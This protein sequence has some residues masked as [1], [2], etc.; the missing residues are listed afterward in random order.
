MDEKFFSFKNELINLFGY[1]KCNRILDEFLEDPLVFYDMINVFENYK[2]SI[3]SIRD[4]KYDIS[5][6][7]RKVKLEEHRMEEIKKEIEMLRKRNKEIRYRN[8]FLE[9]ENYRFCE[10]ISEAKSILNTLGYD[11][12]YN[13][14]DDDEKDLEEDE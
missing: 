3:N 12:P 1:H 9:N 13:D 5:S 4:M 8:T 14:I 2:E 7:E 6:R 10:N 11:F